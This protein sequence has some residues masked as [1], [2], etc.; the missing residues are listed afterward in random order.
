MILISANLRIFTHKLCVQ[1]DTTIVFK[2]VNQKQIV[3]FSG[4]TQAQWRAQVCMNTVKPNHCLCRTGL[5][6]SDGA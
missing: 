2:P 6:V 4:Q 3:S 5:K 1:L